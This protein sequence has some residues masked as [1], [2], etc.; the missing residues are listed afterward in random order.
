MTSLALLLQ[1]S[2]A[3]QDTAGC[4]TIAITWAPMIL[5][6]VFMWWYFRRMGY[7]SGKGGYLQRTVEHMD[8]VEATL[9]KIEEHLRKLVERDDSGS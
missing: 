5:L 8:R 9:T 7:F 6:F 4:I 2:S 1:A 3:T